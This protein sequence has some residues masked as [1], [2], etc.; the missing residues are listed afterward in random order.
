ME[1]R[2]IQ[3]EIEKAQGRLSDAFSFLRIEEKR[4]ELAALDEQTARPD[5]WNDA[6]TA[7]AGVTTINAVGTFVGVVIGASQIKAGK[8]GA[9]DDEG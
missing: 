5:F 4:D 8:G 7:Q 3:K 2:D 6:A 1:L 9:D